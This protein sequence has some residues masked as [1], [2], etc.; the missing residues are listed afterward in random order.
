[1]E[2]REGITLRWKAFSDPWATDEFEGPR[3]DLQDAIR[4]KNRQC[5]R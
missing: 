2:D 5:L 4:R 3:N 1:M